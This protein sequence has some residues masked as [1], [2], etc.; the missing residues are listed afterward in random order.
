MNE[1][2]ERVAKAMVQAMRELE[3]NDANSLTVAKATI[4]AMREPTE[5]MTEV[6]GYIEDCEEQYVGKTTANAVYQAMI[7]KALEE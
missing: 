6:G 3:P 1:M 5:E 4:K 2:I 7:D